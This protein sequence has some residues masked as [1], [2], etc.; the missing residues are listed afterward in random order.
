MIW[1]PL[2]IAVLR[3]LRDSGGPVDL[4][5]YVGGSA[6]GTLARRGVA[7]TADAHRRMWVITDRGRGV[8]SSLGSP[9]RGASC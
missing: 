2:H 7:E 3:V 4:S 9:K 1:T 5:F 6:R 8:L